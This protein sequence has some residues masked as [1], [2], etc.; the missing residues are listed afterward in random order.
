VFSRPFHSVVCNSSWQGNAGSSLLNVL[1]H[2]VA[3]SLASWQL[4]LFLSKVTGLQ[5]YTASALSSHLFSLFYCRRS[6]SRGSV[7]ALSK[8]SWAS[9]PIH[10][11]LARTSGRTLE[12]H[13]GKFKVSGPWSQ[14]LYCHLRK[15]T[16]TVGTVGLVWIF[17]TQGMIHLTYHRQTI[18]SQPQIQ[19]HRPI[20][21]Q[22]IPQSFVDAS[23]SFVSTRMHLHSMVQFG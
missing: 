5:L 17:S 14:L 23:S 22:F 20:I 15:S 8:L 19:H 3:A 4:L 7:I 16:P 12:T 10:I 21:K 6:Y 18:C 11:F 9:L 1:L 13:F 2:E